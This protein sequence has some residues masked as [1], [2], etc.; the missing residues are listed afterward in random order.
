MVSKQE[1]IDAINNLNDEDDFVRIE[2]ESTIA[3]NMPAEINVLHEEVLKEDY[4]KNTKLTM[5]ELLRDLKD[6]TSID[7]FVEL[8]H[9]RNKWV[10]RQS[11]SA[12]AEY[13]EDA[14]DSLLTVVDDESWRARG[15]AIWALAKIARPDTLDVF[16]KASKDEKSFVRGG[17]VHGLGNIGGEEAIAALKELADSDDSGYIKANAITF[18]EKLEE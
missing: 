18:L 11:S 7:V 6:P 9:D 10:R 8:L 12:L 1:V 3:M 2:A 4:P 5:V 16:I 14:V 13:G 17:A 15:G